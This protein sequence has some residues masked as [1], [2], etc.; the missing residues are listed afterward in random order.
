MVWSWWKAGQ[1]SAGAST[2][3]VVVD[4]RDEAGVSRLVVDSIMG[5]GIGRVEVGEEI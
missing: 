5:A 3:V 2:R 4:N 1:R